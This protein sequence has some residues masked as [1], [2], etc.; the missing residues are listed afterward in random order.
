MAVSC[1]STPACNIN[2]H[3]LAECLQPLVPFHQVRWSGALVQKT[4]GREIRTAGYP[5]K[6]VEINRRRCC[7][8]P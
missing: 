3:D 1:P 4:Y 5:L 8:L 7:S 6:A 2:G